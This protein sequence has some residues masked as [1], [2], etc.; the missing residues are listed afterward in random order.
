[1][2]LINAPRALVIAGAV[3]A[4][5]IIAS[6]AHA[7]TISFSDALALSDVE[8]SG[9]LSVPKFDGALGTLT[10]VT[11]EIKGEA[12]SLITIANNGAQDITANATTNIAF[13]VSS[14]LLPLGAS[15]DFTVSA[16]TG[17]VGVGAGQAELF[18]LA[19]SE[20]LS[21][22][23]APS[24]DFLAPGTVDLDF[25]T[26]T[27]F[28]FASTGGNVT[29]TDA[30][31]AGIQFEITYEFDDGVAVIPT[32]AAGL[33][34]ASVFGVFCLSASAARRNRSHWARS[35]RS[36]AR[37]RLSPDRAPETGAQRRNST[38]PSRRFRAWRPTPTQRCCPRRSECVSPFQFLSVTSSFSPLL[39]I[40]PS[41]ELGRFPR[42][43][44]CSSGKQD[45]T[46]QR[47]LRFPINLSDPA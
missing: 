24:A 6:S 15:P 47:R 35:P 8:I 28:A 7:A 16:T 32:P 14:A 2:S 9:T 39:G 46:G 38:P 20:T 5:P 42:R 4:A 37:P 3:F 12:Q 11:F 13:D 17:D 41:Q 45:R 44:F 40:F 27:S 29:F 21:G 31:Q 33:L 1:M 25:I 43:L 26:A 23:V 10:G 22:A 19:G 18:T 36:R 34:M 30:T